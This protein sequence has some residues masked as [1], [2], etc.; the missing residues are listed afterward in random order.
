MRPG[1]FFMALLPLLL[2][3]TVGASVAPVAGTDG[4]AITCLTTTDRLYQPSVQLSVYSPSLQCSS[5]CTVLTMRVCVL[6]VS[7]RDGFTT[8]TTT[9]RKSPAEVPSQY[10]APSTS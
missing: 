1:K 3:L 2:L 5:L 6:Q 8:V 9:L 4:G 7:Q 10:Q